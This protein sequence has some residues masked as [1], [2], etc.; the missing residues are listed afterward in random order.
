M[1]LT[2]WSSRDRCGIAAGGGADDSAG[3]SR[4]S[5]L[6]QRLIEIGDQIVG[7]LEPDRQAQH[8]LASRR[9]SRSCSSVCPH[10]D[11]STGMLTRLSTPPRLAARL[12]TFSRS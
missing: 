10:C 1:T 8:A 6:A 4:A 5:L 12:M 3:G 11:V 2:A 7:V 9:P